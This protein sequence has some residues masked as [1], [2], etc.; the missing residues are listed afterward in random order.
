MFCRKYGGNFNH[1]IKI[2]RAWY[3]I[4]NLR[5]ET[6]LIQFEKIPIHV[7]IIGMM[8]YESTK[9]NLK[10]F[11]NSIETKEFVITDVC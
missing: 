3:L 6:D 4:V 10:E 8:F 1:F 5:F 7:V 11:W 2:G 9:V